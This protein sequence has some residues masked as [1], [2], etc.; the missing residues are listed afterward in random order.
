MAGQVAPTRAAK[1]AQPTAGTALLRRVLDELARETHDHPGVTRAAYGAGEQF[2]HDLVRRE[3]EAAGAVTRT[4]AAGNLYLTR[5]GSDP[6]LPALFFGS[7][8][9][10]VPHG[11]NFDGAA[12]VVAGL[13]VLAEM[14]ARNLVVRRDVTVMVT[15]AE[16]AVW[17]PVSYPGARAAL[18]RLAADELEARRADTGRTLAEH[19]ADAGFD[20]E[21]IRAGTPQVRP[22]DIAAFVEVHIEQ[23]PRLAGMDRPYGIVTAINGG[24]RHLAARCIGA[25]AHSGAE[26]RFSRKDSV[27]GFADLVQ[28]L[29]A[30][31]DRLE[32]EGRQATITFGRVES[33]PRQHGGSRVLGDIGFTLDIRSDR[34]STLEDIA[35]SIRTIC[36]QI[37][38]R[39]NVRFEFDAPLTWAPAPMDAALVEKLTVVAGPASEVPLLASGAGHDTAAFAEAGVPSV[40][41]FVRSEN[42]SHNPEEA[43]DA[44]DLDAVVAMLVRFVT[45]FDGP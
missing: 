30:V 21:T 6:S 1:E 37:E 41:I 31:W 13:A 16:E 9:D 20:P 18:G 5:R 12:G 36:R 26:P 7:H 23:G 42:G 27:L 4:D 29:E 25:Y 44:S 24:F 10:S 15:R 14:A 33:D 32:A 8:L 45:A 39:R 34:E 11:G 22:A 38:V 3:A 43:M 35:A 40:M 28:G 19:M 17:F 2:A